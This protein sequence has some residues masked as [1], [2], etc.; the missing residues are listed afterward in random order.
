MTLRPAK[1]SDEKK[2]KEK[3]QNKQREKEKR[4]KLPPY[5]LIISEGIKTEVHYITGL[6]KLINMKYSELID[7][8]RI[9]VFGTGRNTRG[10]LKY[11]RKYAERQENKVYKR[12][13][14]IYDKDDFPLDD[15]DNTQ[16]SIDDKEYDDVDRKFFAAWSNECIELWFILYFQELT[17]NVGREQYREIL[18]RYFDYDKA[19][20]DIYD[21]IDKHEKSDIELAIS[22]ARKLYEGYGDKTPPSK[23]VPATRIY[24]LVE[25]LR[26]YLS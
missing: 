15:F 5:T 24:E 1:Y 12:I 6:V 23:K 2:L 10:L 14:L 19:A 21:I 16:F 17:A 26:G 13:W 7:A 22:R 25:E 8:D 9:K 11:A 4:H 3:I 18:K 20:V